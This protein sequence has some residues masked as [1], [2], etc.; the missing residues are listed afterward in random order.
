M[1]KPLIQAKALSQH[2]YTDKNNYVA[3]CNGIDLE[4]YKGETL[5]I[6]GESGCGKS[7]LLKM[8]C[9]LEKPVSGEL[10]FDGEDIT[11]LKGNALREHRKNIQMVFQDPSSAF[12]AKMKVRNAIS[13]P[14]RNFKRMNKKQVDELVQNLLEQV[15]LSPEFAERFPHSMS[16][17]QRQRLGIARALALEP[18]VLICDEVTSALDV[19]VQD[20]IMQLLV[21]IQKEK[22][23]GIIFVCHNLALVQSISH[24]LMVMYLG[25]VMEI[26]PREKL[27]NNAMHPYT[28]ALL[29]SVFVIDHAK[30]K[31]IIPLQ[32][33]A[34][35][36]INRPKGCPFCGR[37]NY[38]TEKCKNQKPLLKEVAQGHKIA[39]FKYDDL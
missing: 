22:Q 28:Q 33:E 12:Y 31:V 7:S 9:S 3:A 26:I 4:L 34:P 32:G 38:V 5:G 8:L 2:Y 30:E 13:E 37:C 11:N 21:K 39:C 23:L 24:R 19:S 20:K 25:H 29:Q 10:I 17:G 16:G 1:S 27:E 14:V 36:N 6:V 15:Q 35:S 18:K